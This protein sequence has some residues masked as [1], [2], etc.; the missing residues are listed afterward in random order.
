MPRRRR[1]QRR[2]AGMALAALLALLPLWAFAAEGADPPIRIGVLKFGSL[3]WELD[4]IARHGLDRKHGFT[5][6]AVPLAGAQALKVAL[7]AD[8]VDVILS[9]WLWVSRI[10][11]TGSDVTFAPYGAWAGALILSPALK[12]KTLADLQGLRIGV[13]GGQIDKNWL[14]LQALAAKEAGLRLAD[15]AEIVFAAPP[16]LRMELQ[17]GRV[18]AV[19]TYWQDAA[20]LQTAGFRRLLDS[21]E[22]ARRLGVVT[23]VPFLGYVFS[24]AWAE[25]HGAPLRGFLAASREAKRI[26]RDSDAEWE[27]IAPLTRSQGAA[28]RAAVR[29]AYRRGLLEHWG[30]EER[31][32]A[33][34]LFR[35]LAETGG[36]SLTGGQA[37][38]A[39]GTFW[40]ED[41]F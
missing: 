9:D 17:S 19:L 1:I 28:E 5:L 40:A 2:A 11:Q 41:R 39:P 10:R 15:A 12:I 29:D 24:T 32:A 16:F 3:A 7:Q 6:E 36:A 38:L 31:L 4:V 34:A 25:A 30:D 37:G 27:R 23:R 26:L 33:K 22:I 20:M 18:D 35:I 14:L 21:A 13:A 8:R